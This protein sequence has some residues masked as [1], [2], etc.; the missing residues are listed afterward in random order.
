[1]KLHATEKDL[2]IEE[3]ERLISGSVNI[4]TCEFTFDEIWDGYTV[5]AVFSTGNRAVMMDIVDGKCAIPQEVLR[6]NVKFRVGIVGVN[7]DIT[8]PTTYSEWVMVEQGAIT[9][10]T[11]GNEGGGGSGGN[12]S[13]S[14]L[15]V[16]PTGQEIVVKA[17]EGKGFDPVTVYGDEN[18]IPMNI[19]EGVSIY[20]VEG[21]ARPYIEPDDPSGSASSL[22]VAKIDFSG[23]A[24]ATDATFKETLTDGRIIYYKATMVAN[25]VTSITNGG[26]TTTVDWGS[27]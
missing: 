13:L 6:P 24:G 23:L 27:V 25:R 1:M 9:T 4:Y 22:K 17:D 18:L 26:Y 11:K 7:G 15:S 16:M 21:T 14:P 5:T 20:G 19:V 2:L 10:A 8:R 12:V 3:C